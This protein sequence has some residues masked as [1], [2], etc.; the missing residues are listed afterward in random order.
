MIQYVWLVPLFP[1]IGFLITGL[2][3]N[4]LGKSS[5]WIASM[6]ILASFIVSCIIFFDVQALPENVFEKGGGPVIV[7][8]FDF[9]KTQSMQIGFDFQV[10]AL[11]S[12]FLLVITGIGFLIHLYSISYM[13]HDD[14]YGKFFSYLNLF[15][16]S[17]LLLVLGANYLIMFIGWEGVGLCS[18]LLIGFWYKNVAYTD[19]AK[20]AFIMNRIGD[21]GFLIGIF[22]IF[23]R[24][25]TLDFK[26]LQ[27]LISHDTYDATFISSV[28]LC[29]FVGATGKSAQLPLFTWLPDA[30]AGPTPVSA[31]I[32]AA[33]MVTAGIYMI[34][35]SHFIYSIAPYAQHVILIIGLATALIAATIATQQNDIK[36][37]L[38][39]STV[40]QLGFMFMALGVGAYTAAI[41]HVV[42]HAFF[43]AL[44]FLG[45]G[46]V[47]HAV[48]GEQDIRHMGGLKKYMKTTYATF[49]IGCI[50]IAGIPPLSGFFSKDEIMMHVFTYP[51]YGNIFW[52]LGMLAALMTAY[53]MFR[54]LFITFHGEYR[55]KGHPHESPAL[56]T[57][58]LIVLAI[59]SALGGL[60]GIPE[61]L[62]GHHALHEFLSP[63]LLKSTGMNA[64]VNHLSHESEYIL[65]GVAVLIAVIGILIAWFGYKKYNAAAEAKGIASFFEQ[66]WYFDEAY[67]N[68]IVKPLYH[69][70]SFSEKV[71]EK[72]GLDG[73]VNGIGKMI[74]LGSTRLRLLQSGLVGF[75]LFLIV[76]GIVLLFALQLLYNKFL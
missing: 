75:Y 45:S 20:K 69:I 15:I 66:K 7:Q 18:Y 34:T 30:M 56:M 21:L 61:V 53:Y 67:D 44:L 14:G 39:Y 27:F 4:T 40:S 5:G 48:D 3:R 50:A 19:A 72:S 74:Q 10:D 2:G 6:A 13:G 49:L 55:G 24:Y 68:I 54:L 65:M 71:I 22:L 58:P 38:A 9:I 35:R 25:N 47:I 52:V 51:I 26:S 8:L 70:S 1:L 17:M 37:V 32:H 62:G 43:K 73:I 36:K 46:S 63:V 41:F 33:T 31:L 60:I 64:N 28:A 29:F 76:I 57:I 23:S 42:T 12:I 59:F 16:F 11:T